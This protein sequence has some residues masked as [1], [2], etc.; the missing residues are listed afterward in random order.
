MKINSLKTP[1]VARLA[2][3]ASSLVGNRQCACIHMHVCTYSGVYR[4]QVHEPLPPIKTAYRAEAM[5]YVT[6]VYHYM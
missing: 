6:K 3:H 2:L 4:S 1:Q 5:C